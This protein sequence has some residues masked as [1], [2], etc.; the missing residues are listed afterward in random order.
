MESD[1]IHHQNSGASS[2]DLAAGVCISIVHNYLERVA[3]H[4]PLGK[5]VLFM[6]GGGYSAVKAAF[7]QQ[8]L[9]DS[10]ACVFRVRAVG[11]ALKALGKLELKEI[12]QG[13][14]VIQ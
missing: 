8:T 10:N 1:L 11:A 12:V 4:K 5:R 14:R 7:E 13:R 3:N 2:A 9:R 6:G